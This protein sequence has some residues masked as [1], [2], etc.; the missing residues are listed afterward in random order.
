[1]G[2]CM[3]KPSRKR[4]RPVFANHCN[5]S[6]RTG[7]HTHAHACGQPCRHCNALSA[8]TAESVLQAQW[9]EVL[10]FFHDISRPAVHAAAGLAS[11]RQLTGDRNETRVCRTLGLFSKRCH[12][13]FDFASCCACLLSTCLGSTGCARRS[14]GFWPYTALDCIA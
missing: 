8:N 12:L 9:C 13:D 4:V 6:K 14:K 7:K 10:P 11:P 1:M 5:S 3:H 2:G